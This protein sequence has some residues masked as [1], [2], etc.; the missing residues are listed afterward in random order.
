MA[1]DVVMEGTDGEMIPAYK[2]ILAS[3]SKF[4][5]TLFYGDFAESSSTGIVQYYCHTDQVSSMLLDETHETTKSFVAKILELLISAADYFALPRLVG[6]VTD[7][8]ISRMHHEV[9]ILAWKFLVFADG[10]LGG[11]TA[12]SHKAM[13]IIAKKFASSSDD[14]PFASIRRSLLEKIYS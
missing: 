14:F 1:S 9:A 8:V 6:S 5:K 11:H 3:R 10:L 7:W 12:I 2:L 13:L 4:F